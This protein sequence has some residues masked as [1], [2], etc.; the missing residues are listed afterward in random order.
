M[1][2]HARF[3]PRLRE[4]DIERGDRPGQTAADAAGLREPWLSDDSES[5]VS[6]VEVVAK[7]GATM[8]SQVLI[9][10]IDWPAQ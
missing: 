5:V 4:A 1:S 6:A 8:R 2:H 7:N 10:R 3:R 9:S